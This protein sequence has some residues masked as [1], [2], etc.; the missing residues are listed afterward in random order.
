MAFKISKTARD[1]M[2]FPRR[3]SRPISY[4]TYEN[5]A[6]TV[7]WF[8]TGRQIKKAMNA[9]AKKHFSGKDKS[10]LN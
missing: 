9:Y 4:T 10:L 7:A 6:L 8:N 5:D 3:L 2:N 1:A